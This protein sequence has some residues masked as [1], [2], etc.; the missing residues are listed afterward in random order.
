MPYIEIR[1]VKGHSNNEWNNYAD[2]LATKASALKK[3]QILEGEEDNG[4]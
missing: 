3:K 2:E 4:K 1:N